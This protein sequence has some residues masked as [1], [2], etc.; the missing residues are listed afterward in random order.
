MNGTRGIAV[1]SVLLFALTAAALAP[2]ALGPI[3]VT[4]AKDRDGPFAN[5]SPQVQVRNRAKDLYMRARNQSTEIEEIELDDI[6]NDPGNDFKIRWYRGDT[7]ITQHARNGGYGFQLDAD[8]RQKFRVR[9]KPRV[10]DPGALCLTGRFTVAS[11][12]FEP[13]G[14]F[15]VNSSSICG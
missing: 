3:R 4:V 7:E 15:Y 12:D 5:A 6:S 2:A 10:A 1:A 14:F 11:E 13:L 8:E 9:V